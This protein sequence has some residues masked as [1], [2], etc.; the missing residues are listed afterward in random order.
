MK[1]N[2]IRELKVKRGTPNRP[3]E[4]TV[5]L[6][7]EI[8]EELLETYQSE[9]GDYQDPPDKEIVDEWINSLISYALEDDEDWRE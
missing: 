8:D 1:I 2:V 5:E 6:L 4:P 7:M 3:K 9:T